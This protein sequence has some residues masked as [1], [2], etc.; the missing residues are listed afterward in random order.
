MLDHPQTEIFNSAQTKLDLGNHKIMINKIHIIGQVIFNSN[1]HLPD[2]IL[3]LIRDQVTS[4]RLL[5][6]DEIS[7]HIQ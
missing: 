5:P 3:F 6:P 4:S 7:V 2:K 1:P